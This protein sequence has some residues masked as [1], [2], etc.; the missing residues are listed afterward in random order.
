MFEFDLRKDLKYSPID[1]STEGYYPCRSGEDSY[2]DGICRC[3]RI[4]EVT[5]NTCPA[6]AGDLLKRILVGDHP[7]EDLWFLALERVFRKHLCSEMFEASWSA[8]YYG[9]EVDHVYLDGSSSAWQGF[10]RDV[11]EVFEVGEPDL[12]EVIQRMLLVEYSSLLSKIQDVDYWEIKSLNM[13]EVHTDDGVISRVDKEIAQG[14]LTYPPVHK[15]QGVALFDGEKYRLVDGFHRY[16]AW[17]GA[18]QPRWGKA[19]EHRK[20]NL[21]CGLTE[22]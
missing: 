15:V 3:Y 7:T 5:F 1:Y 10:L 8:N 21:L 6:Q 13:S 20:V 12:Y 18:V 2:C 4:T 19:P 11:H 14:Y 9:D 17:S 16:A 22:G